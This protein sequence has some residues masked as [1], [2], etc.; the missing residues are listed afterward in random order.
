[1]PN[2]RKSQG[3]KRIRLPGKPP[4]RF[5]SRHPADIRPKTGTTKNLIRPKSP[6]QKVA[7]CD[8][9][10]YFWYAKDTQQML[11]VSTKGQ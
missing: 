7:R 9:I 2:G 4:S 1:M 8:E 3:D 5:G 10:Y 6:A 11:F